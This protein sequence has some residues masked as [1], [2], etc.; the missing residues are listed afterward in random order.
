MR[1]REAIAFVA[2]GGATALSMVPAQNAVASETRQYA[3]YLSYP[4]MSNEEG[5]C[6]P[7]NPDSIGILREG[8]RLQGKSSAEIEQAVD[9]VQRGDKR[10]DIS[11]RGKLEGKTVDAY[12]YP[13]SVPDSQL[14]L[15]QG[16]V[17][18]GFNLDGKDKPEDF[19]DPL[20][21]ERGVDNQL[22]RVLGCSRPW[23]AKIGEAGPY[24]LG[25][26]EQTFES[27]PAW[28][29]DISG[30]DSAE[31]DDDVEVRVLLAKQPLARNALGT[32]LAYLTF[33]ADPITRTA[34]NVVHGSIK[35]GRLT[36][37]KFDFYLPSEP[38][39]Q[40]EYGLRDARMRFE[41]LP[42]GRLKG[43]VGGYQDWRPLYITLAL[44][45]SVG[46]QSGSYD[47]PGHYYAFRKLA[48]A[49]PDPKTGQNMYIS[50]AYYLEA[51][52]AFI[53]YPEPSQQLTRAQ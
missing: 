21:G 11:M 40:A 51:V 16:H 36:T 18:I 38:Q 28:L 20:T 45:R 23:R 7:S 37:G 12:L 53:A 13:F 34:G 49:Y 31:N 39:K 1:I 6:K 33:T 25:K 52:P 47:T 15:V 19:V 27:A 42:D 24:Q 17:G 10:P 35:N 4:A 29:I 32:A 8:L 43:I 14:S 48:D 50:S 46:E 3:V 5:D 41:F 22:F 30:I 2:V 26:W 44:R 9:G